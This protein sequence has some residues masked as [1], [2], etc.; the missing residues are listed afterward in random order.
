MKRKYLAIMMG[1]VLS[2]TSMN[3]YAVSAAETDTTTESAEASTEETAEEEL[4]EDA[5]GADSELD[6][7]ANAPEVIGQ[8]TDVSEESIMI[9]V[10]TLSGE[11]TTEAAAETTASQ[12]LTLN[13]QAMEVYLDD[14]ITFQKETNPAE[15]TVEEAS[16]EEL[17]ESEAAEEATEAEA[18]EETTEVT[19]AETEEET[20][21]TTEAAAEAE[22]AEASE[23]LEEITI[24][25]IKVGDIV[26]ILSDEN[27]QVTSIIV[28]AEGELTDAQEEET[29]ET[30][31]ETADENAEDGSVE[32]TEETTEETAE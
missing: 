3:V 21:E 27:G 23:E 22:P 14:T 6:E 10:G 5:S 17:T 29:A 20:T 31:E 28:L 8:V 1:M 26:K 15:I 30:T 19:E 18:A 9:S 13:G 11:E 25:D 16:E 4:T 12:T 32:E 24:S 2:L 7:L